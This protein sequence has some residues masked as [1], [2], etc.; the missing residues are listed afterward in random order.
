[1]SDLLLPKPIEFEWDKYNQT[2][3][4]LKHGVTPKEAEEIFFHE[5][6]VKKKG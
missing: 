5:V 6:L 2:K 3:I 1:M 4:R